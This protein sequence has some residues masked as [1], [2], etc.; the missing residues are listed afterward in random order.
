M[1]VEA[2]GRLRAALI[3]LL[4][5]TCIA[6]VVMT[7][8]AAV[9]RHLDSAAGDGAGPALDVVVADVDS[10]GRSGLEILAM[11]RDRGWPIRVVLTARDLTAPLQ[12]TVGRMGA[13]AL[14]PRPETTDGWRAV[15][16]TVMVL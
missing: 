6:A 4:A 16:R 10:P 11:A 9:I 12:A 8:V 3:E 1:I 7:D 15:L 14:L 2:D 5:E 13:A